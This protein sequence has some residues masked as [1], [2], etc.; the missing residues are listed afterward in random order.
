MLECKVS[1]VKEGRLKIISQPVQRG[2]EREKECGTKTS[3]VH[4][5]RAKKAGRVSNI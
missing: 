2:P 4:S 3:K 1:G 5:R